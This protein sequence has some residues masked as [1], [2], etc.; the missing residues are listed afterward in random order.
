MWLC[1]ELGES[2]SLMQDNLVQGAEPAACLRTNDLT[3]SSM[4]SRESMNKKT[5][6]STGSNIN[7]LIDEIKLKL[8]MHTGIKI[9]SSTNGE[10]CSYPVSSP[11]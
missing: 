4:G 6:H 10:E 8:A 11:P 5:Q 3:L 9:A 7:M 2:L 1:A